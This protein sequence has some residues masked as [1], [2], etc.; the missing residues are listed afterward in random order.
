MKKQKSVRLKAYTLKQIAALWSDYLGFPLS[1]EEV[2]D[3]LKMTDMFCWRSPRIS[4]PESKEV[5]LF[6]DLFDKMG[7]TELNHSTNP[8]LIAINLIEYLSHCEQHGHKA[9]N[10]KTLIRK[11]PDSAQHR[12]VAKSQV[13]QSRVKGQ[14]IR[15]WI[16]QRD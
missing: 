7:E 12:F 14:S 2:S 10:R 3:M 5:K 11:L 6:W 15:C 4:K 16:F 13:I 9:P 1:T 8:S